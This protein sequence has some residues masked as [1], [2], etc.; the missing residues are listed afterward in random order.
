[1]RRALISDVHG[2]IDALNCVLDSI[3]K[4]NID[5]IICLGDILGY[6]PNPI[7]CVDTIAERCEWSLLGNHDYA[8][9]YEP[10][11]FNKA[12]AE[13]AIWTRTKIDSEK[14][15]PLIAKRWDFL[16]QLKVRVHFDDFLCVH[17]SA[18]RPINEYVFPNDPIES[19]KKII[20]IF[21][22]IEK[23]CICGHTH[24]PGIFTEE[25]DFYSPADFDNNT[26]NLS[27][28]KIII[29][30]VSVGQPR[31]GIPLSSYAILDQESGTVEFKRVEY[32]YK[33]VAEKIYKISE[34]DNWLGD[35]LIEGR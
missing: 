30:P 15:E 24:V 34:L 28:E 27:D 2:N 26:Y 14:S 20:S 3:D 23:Y 35:R 22:R 7:E 29:N 13:S 25:P 4:S 32:D 19:E 8:A 31:D 21:N 12:A 6:G 11:N 5:S 33:K 16:G 18:R 10:T 9:L 1:M 17:G